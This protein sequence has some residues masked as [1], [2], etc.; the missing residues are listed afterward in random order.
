MQNTL[1]SCLL[2][3]HLNRLLDQFKHLQRAPRQRHQSPRP[4]RLCL[5][6]VSFY[7]SPKAMSIFPWVSIIISFTHHHM[8]CLNINTAPPT[9]NPTS[10]PTQS[11]SKSPSCKFIFYLTGTNFTRFHDK[12]TVVSC[13]HFCPI[14]TQ[15]RQLRIPRRR[16][17]S[18][19]PS[20]QLFR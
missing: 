2:K 15:L 19:L 7:L 11:P 4:S 5:Q 8:N 13:Y 9:N 10:S 20:S 17:A 12:L 1:L 18:R 3:S 14:Q 6:P 16:Q